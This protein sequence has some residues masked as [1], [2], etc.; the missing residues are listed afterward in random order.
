MIGLVLVVERRPVVSLTA[1]STS[2]VVE[3]FVTLMRKLHTIPEWTEAFNSF[4]ISK[5]ATAAD[6]LS[7]PSLT[8]QVRRD[9]VLN[10]RNRS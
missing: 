5:L 1:S 8:I 7:H 10:C 2:S 9:V 4:M 3:E 6:L